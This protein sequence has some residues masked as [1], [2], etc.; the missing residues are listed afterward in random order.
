MIKY[1]KHKEMDINANNSLNYGR[2]AWRTIL[3]EKP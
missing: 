1:K 2:G 3:A